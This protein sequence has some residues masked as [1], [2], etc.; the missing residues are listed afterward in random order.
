MHVLKDV[1]EWFLLLLASICVFMVGYY[2]NSINKNLNSMRKSMNQLMI[3]NG[4]MKTEIDGLKESLKN[5]HTIIYRK[6]GL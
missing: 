5:I 3:D 4:S 2:F 6:V 1:P